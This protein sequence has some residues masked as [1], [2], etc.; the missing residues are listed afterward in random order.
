M[1]FGFSDDQAAIRDSLTRLLG[2]HATLA[3][4]HQRLDAAQGFDTATWVALA[5]GGWL[6][7]AI[8]EQNGGAGMGAVELA[9]LAEEIGRSLAAVPFGPVLGLAV[10]AIQAMGSDSQRAGLL[11]RIASGQAVVAAALSENGEVVPPQPSAW[12]SNGRLFGRKMPVSFGAT[13]S[14]ALAAAA[15]D[16]GAMRLYL[17]P[18]DHAGV[19]ITPLDPI[20]RTR[21]AA[22]IDF[23]GTPAEPLPGSD[24]AAIRR[25]VD[26]AA[27]LAAFEQI[28]VA[29]AALALTTAYA[30]ERRAFGRPIG[31]FQAV[32]HRLADMFA[33]IE[34]ARSNAFF[35]VWALAS[36]DRRLP[37]AA[38]VA[39]L[40]ALDAV[41]FVTEESIQLHGG[42]GFTWAADPHLFLR[43]GW[44]LKAELGPADAWRDR[45][46]DNLAG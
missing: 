9:I 46:I 13:A 7:L 17:A 45:L 41:Q 14:H 16:A 32:K 28:G 5:E 42:I 18:L 40:T 36:G 39:R 25:L 34:L 8:P 6:G 38:A 22:A 19:T 1:N 29:E 23:D 44:Q 37:E 30:R 11:P 31:G 26:G 35:G 3:V 10:P 43:R 24:G 4:A 20:D 33:K 12:V 2:D 15:D 27:V 21:P